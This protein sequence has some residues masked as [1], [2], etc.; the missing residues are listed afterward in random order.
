M[1]LKNLLFLGLCG[2][3]LTALGATLFQTRPE[4]IDRGH[5][6]PI[7]AASFDAALERLNAAIRRGWAEENLRP[8]PEADDLTR[9]RRLSLALEGT[10]PA[11]EEIRQL[12][13][14]PAE[15]RLTRW[16]DRIFAD[17]R[18]ADYLAER[19]A[20]PLVGVEDGPF[21]LYRRRRFVAW[22]AD[23]L[24]A[25][26]PYDQIIRE[27]IASEGLWTDHPATN[28]ITATAQPD[29]GNEP[30]INKLAGRV[31]RGMLGVRL[32]CAECHDHP[33]DP[34]WRQRDFQA[35]AAFFA[36]TRPTLTGL[37]D[38]AGPYWIEDPATG[39]ETIIAPAAP[40]AEDLL[41]RNGTGRERLA[42]W[43]TH[44]DNEPFARAIVNRVWTL[45]LGRPL[46]AVVDDIP[47]EGP[48]PEALEILA[49]DFSS[50]GFQLQ[51]LIRLI[52][53]SDAFRRASR[54]EHELTAKHEARWAAYPLTRLRP[55][56]VVGGILQA[57][58]LTALDYDAHILTRLSK[59]NNQ[60]EFIQRYG[61]G[62]ANELQ[63]T[64]G[65]IPQR[66]LLL[67][68]ALVQEKIRDNLIGNA[69]T[70][71]AALAPDDAAAVETA[72]LAVL[73]RRPTEDELRH[74]TERLAGTQG[75]QRHARLADLYWA[76]L[77]STEFS[78]NH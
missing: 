42:Q 67:N 63:P 7:D 24:Y 69:A 11:L 52:A 30:D 62:G 2:A 59:F 21:L 35:L 38:D 54:A 37:R 5:L 40:W 76:L 55:E 70:R 14:W 33:F 56:Q 34:R 66:L 22:L 49:D 77:N 68:G 74:F 75:R 15:A 47:T 61:D 8:A 9:A 28:F 51:R 26:R 39:A 71:I 73:T 41:P 27:S 78:W 23:Q 36:P 48:L 57:S 10:I 29:K 6:A 46:T 18:S 1:W 3:G 31:S 32:D 16:L 13:R 44:P 19:L 4:G 58:S 17:R 25:A 60:R 45:L 43:V 65:T 12:E 53:A 50:R 64:A 72:Y 20:R